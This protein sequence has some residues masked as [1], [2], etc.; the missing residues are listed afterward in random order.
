M[1]DQAIHRVALAYDEQMTLHCYVDEPEKPERASSWIPEKPE[2]IKTIYDQLVREGLADRCHRVESREATRKELEW[3]HDHDHLNKMEASTT[4]ERHELNELE[5]HYDI[6]DI[7]LCPETQKAALLAA[8][9]ALQVVESILTGESRSGVAVIRPPGHHAEG[10]KAYGFC[11]Y[12]N[13]ATAAKYAIEA[14]GLERVLIVDWD[15][16]HGNG[17]QKM[18]LDDPRVLYVSLHRLDT[19]PWIV[20]SMD[21]P[22]VGTGPGKGYNVNI[23][24]PKPMMGDA[25]YLA[26]FQRIIMPIAYQFNPQLV[27]VAAGFD[28][29]RGDQLGECDVTPE[30][31]GQLTH[32]LTS[33]AFGRVAVLLEGGY[34]LESTSNSMTMCV[35]ALLGDQLPPPKVGPVDPAGAAA[36]HRVIK[37]LRPYWTNLQS[38][39][40]VNNNII[41]LN[42]LQIQNLKIS[43]SG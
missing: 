24:W 41:D 39:D 1:S 8:G 2:R 15:I 42:K 18:F 19:F 43:Q 33:L 5:V 28:A 40:D 25:E 30:G 32:L 20:E 10:D 7:Y 31:Y 34:N 13:T 3:L 16:H 29:A 17:I 9:S 6:K 27:L 11:I 35:K 12:N 37:H 23:G 38:H 26:A 4:M 22:V 14:H 21:C 36:I